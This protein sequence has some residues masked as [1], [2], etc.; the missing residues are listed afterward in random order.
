MVIMDGNQSTD[1]R[2][3]K[4]FTNIITGGM[5]MVI[6]AGERFI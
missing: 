2:V 4:A 1:M 5:C 6:M 3:G